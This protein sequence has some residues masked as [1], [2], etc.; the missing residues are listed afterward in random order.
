[1]LDHVKEVLGIFVDTVVSPALARTGEIDEVVRALK[2]GLVKYVVERHGAPKD[3]IARH[4]GKSDRWLYRQLE[5]FETARK[6]PLEPHD[7]YRLLCDVLNYYT[8]LAPQTAGVTECARHLRAIKW[9]ISTLELE[10]S[11]SLYAG[12]GYL[13]R[14]ES[15]A[16]GEARFRAVSSTYTVKASGEQERLQLLS[17]HMGA[18]LPI[19]ISYLRG[20]E[21]ARFSMSEGEVLEKHLIAAVRDIW[22]YQVKRLNQAVEESIKEDPDET[23]RKVKYRAMLLYGLGPFFDDPRGGNS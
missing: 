8:S 7:G 22:Q 9:K 13:E 12:M 6:E 20:D 4:L 17:R 21:V 18:V 16:G 1:M 5:D 15:E 14:V 19:A 23:G 11:L 2:Q 10:P 3:V